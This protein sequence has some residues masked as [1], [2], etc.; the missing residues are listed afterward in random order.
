MS[1]DLEVSATA[2]L[3]DGDEP[4]AGHQV[5]ASFAMEP[6]APSLAPEV[7]VTDE[8][9]RASIV[10]PVGA[11]GVVFSTE[12][13]STSCDVEAEP[14]VVTARVDRPHRPDPLPVTG[15]GELVGGAGMLVVA[16]GAGLV[17]GRGRR[18]VIRRTG[19]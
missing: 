7:L 5:F 11:I 2:Y 15:R 8:D 10:L 12:S 9:G 17:L 1:S 16:V 3:H 18:R 4:L 6:S 19:R 14:E 13:P